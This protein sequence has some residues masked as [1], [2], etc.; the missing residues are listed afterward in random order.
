MPHVNTPA[1]ML[2]ICRYN[3][4]PTP[5]GLGPGLVG[6][7]HLNK[8]RVYI[9]LPLFSHYRVLFYF[10]PVAWLIELSLIDALERI[11]DKHDWGFTKMPRDYKF[12]QEEEEENC[13]CITIL[14]QVWLCTYLMC[15]VLFCFLFLFLLFCSFFFCLVFLVFGFLWK[16]QPSLRKKLK[17]TPTYKKKAH[18]KRSSLYI[19][20]P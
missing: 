2:P 7:V 5:S 19:K 8:V 13:S 4:Q 9:F 3:R 12:F 15:F 18:K 6:H 11:E 16:P 14:Y 20:W 17:N 10:V 1:C